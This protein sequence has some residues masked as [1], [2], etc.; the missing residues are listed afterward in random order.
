[1]SQGRK[2][3]KRAFF[4]PFILSEGNFFDICVLSQC[5]VYRIH[6]QNIHTFRYQKSSL[7][8]LLLLVFNIIKS[9]QY[10]LKLESVYV[11]LKPGWKH[12]CPLSLLLEINPLTILSA[13]AVSSREVNPFFVKFILPAILYIWSTSNKW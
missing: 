13:S 10:I 2:R 8:T 7:H 12:N 5:I 3:K 11:S 9:L 6:F 1:M 4:V